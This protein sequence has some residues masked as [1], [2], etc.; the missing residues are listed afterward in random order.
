MAKP[1]GWGEGGYRHV[2]TSL[3]KG[4]IQIISFSE[5]HI[6]NR[7][8]K[9]SGYITKFPKRDETRFSLLISVNDQNALN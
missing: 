6:P 7:N 1:Q 9:Y 3:S 8:P 4:V 5:L 2:L